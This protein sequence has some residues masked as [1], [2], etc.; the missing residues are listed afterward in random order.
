LAVGLYQ[1]N[2]DI[3]LGGPVEFRSSLDIS[4][5]FGKR[6]RIGVELYHISNARLYERNPGINA[7]AFVQTF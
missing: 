5:A 4:R 2:G 1:G 6:L 3:D 7:L